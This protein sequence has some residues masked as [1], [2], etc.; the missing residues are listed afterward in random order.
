MCNK[1]SWG[2]DKTLTQQ[3]LE[4]LYQIRKDKG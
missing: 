3:V 4:A 1:I 2:N